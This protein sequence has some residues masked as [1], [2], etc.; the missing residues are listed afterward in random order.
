MEFDDFV[1]ERK[2]GRRQIEAERRRS[3]EV[4]DQIEPGRLQDGQCGGLIASEN[5]ADIDTSLAVR[6]RKARAVADE[7]AGRCA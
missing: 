1:G 2:Q 7:T 3:L 5:A 4:D 6:V